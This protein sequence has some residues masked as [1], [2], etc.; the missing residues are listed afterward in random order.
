MLRGLYTAYTGM[1]AQQRKLDVVSNNLANANTTGFK[2]DDVS[3]KSFKE[4]LAIKINDPQIRHNQRI[5]EFS[6]GV[7]L[8]K[9]FTNFEQ[10]GL[11]STN[12]PYSVAI[13]GK[14][15]FV[16]SKYEQ[17]GMVKSYYTRDG[18]FTA[19]KDGE[20]VTKDGAFVNGQ[21]GRIK[22]PGQFTINRDGSIYAEGELI[23]KIQVTDF[24]DYT[25]LDKVGDSFYQLKPAGQLKEFGG[26]L[27]QSNLESSNVNS[28]KE[29]IDMISLQ[30]IYEANQKVLQTYDS[31][32]DKTVNSVGKV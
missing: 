8:N 22:L 23:D 21:N 1:T 20:L 25:Y 16:V 3:F 26:Q 9:V 7:G 30:R 15:M 11:V 24:E 19:N 12:D 28:V 18:S 32:L 13:E 14:G 6:L 10:G 17:D 27:L 2:Q 4:V 29:M 5:G 31:T